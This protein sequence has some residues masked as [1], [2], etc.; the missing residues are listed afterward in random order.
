M[1]SSKYTH[2]NTPNSS[3]GDITGTLDCVD[4]PG[5]GLPCGT[6]IDIWA[7]QQAAARSHHP[8]GVNVVFA[9][10]HGMFIGDTLDSHLWKLLASIDDGQIITSGY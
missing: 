6:G 9:D 5:D 10:G 4:S 8:G 2:Q 1:G 7:F 3:V